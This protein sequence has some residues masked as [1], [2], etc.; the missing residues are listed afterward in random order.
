[1]LVCLN[2]KASHNVTYKLKRFINNNVK[3]KRLSYSDN[4][5]LRFF[6]KAPYT[7]LIYHMCEA[8]CPFILL[9]II[10]QIVLGKQ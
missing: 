3:S 1:M 4:F 8:A 9:D 5:P 2:H 7:L 6:C 10:T